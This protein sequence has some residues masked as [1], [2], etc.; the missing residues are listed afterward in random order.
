MA[1]PQETTEL[2]DRINGNITYWQ[3]VREDATAQIHKFMDAKS[4][5]IDTYKK[6][7]E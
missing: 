2:I 6:E 4:E 1:S 7:E 5:L 3:A